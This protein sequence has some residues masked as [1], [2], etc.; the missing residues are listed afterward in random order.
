MTKHYTN[1]NYLTLPYS[2]SVSQT[3][4]QFG[5]EFHTDKPATEKNTVGQMCLVSSTV[6]PGIIDWQIRVIV[7]A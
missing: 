6:E 4:W 1:S 5:R 2:A 7:R 3:T